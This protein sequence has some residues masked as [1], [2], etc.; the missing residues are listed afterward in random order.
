[1]RIAYIISA[2][3]LPLQLIRLVNKVNAPNVSIII[4]IDKKT[5]DSIFN[6]IHSKLSPYNNVHF[7]D[8]HVCNWGDFG[9]VMASLKGIKFIINNNIKADYVFLATGQ[10]YPLASNDKI[11]KFLCES[12]DKSFM[13]YMPFPCR[14]QYGDV[15]A[16]LSGLTGDD[17]LNSQGALERIS[18]EPCRVSF[19]HIYKMGKH[20]RFPG[21][22]FDRVIKYRRKVPGGIKVFWGRSYWCLSME[23]I[24]YIDNYVS[25]HADY[26]EFFK[27][28][29]IP[30]EIFFQSIVMN[31]PFAH[32]IVN[33]SLTYQKWFGGVK[34]NFLDEDDLHLLFDAG[35]L[36]ARKFD[37][38]RNPSVLDYI[39]NK[40]DH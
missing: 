35:E 36:F 4:H 28:V 3:Q 22:F 11:V 18:Q 17:L 38:R 27:Y 14:G 8:R 6:F 16:Y 33:K 39:D 9:H 25:K 12:N 21:L 13:S 5:D 24:K 31:S 40:I 34:R 26:L 37:L 10:D 23:L 20:L 2:Y 30:D 32:T 1:M 19:F 15:N 7:L 29:L